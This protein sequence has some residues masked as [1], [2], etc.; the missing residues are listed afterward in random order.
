MKLKRM[1]ET[2]RRGTSNLSSA[3]TRK[4]SGSCSRV[5]VRRVARGFQTS[6][7]CVSQTE[8][9]AR[10]L[11]AITS[12]NI[13]R[14]SRKKLTLLP[15]AWFQRTG[16]SRIRSPACC[17]TLRVRSEEHTS[18]LQSRFDLVCRLLLEKKNNTT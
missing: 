14:L 16:I 13:R 17:A 11:S 18:E 5:S 15:S 8:R 4:S 9:Y 2:A 1:H 12:R 7:R 6:Q 10:A 3:T